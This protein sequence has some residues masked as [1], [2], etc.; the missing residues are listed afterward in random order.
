MIRNGAFDY[1][2]KPVMEASQPVAGAFC[3]VRRTAA[4]MEDCRSE[5]GFAVST[6]GKNYRQ[7]NGSKGIEEN[8]LGLVQ[9]LFIDKVTHCFSVDEVV[10]ETGLSK[11]TTRRYLE[12]CVEAGF[13]SVEI[14]SYTGKLGIRE[15]CTGGQR[16]EDRAI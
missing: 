12:H 4:G 11:T 16:R 7:D 6:S 9:A 2:L 3:S 5:R 1:I 14:K 10:S 15:G 8:T 13:L